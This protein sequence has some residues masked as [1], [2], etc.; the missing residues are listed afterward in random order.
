MPDLS[1]STRFLGLSLCWTLTWKVVL[2]IAKE[3]VHANKKSNRQF[4]NLDK[5]VLLDRIASIVTRDLVRPLAYSTSIG[6]C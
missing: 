4:V 2:S 3:N 1:T 5:R 6:E